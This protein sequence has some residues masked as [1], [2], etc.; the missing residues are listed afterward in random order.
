MVWRGAAVEAFSKSLN[1]VKKEGIKHLDLKCSLQ[2]SPTG[3]DPGTDFHRWNGSPHKIPLPDLQWF[4]C[5]TDYS[6][7][8]WSFLW[9]F[10]KLE[11]LLYG[12]TKHPTPT[13]SRTGIEESL[14]HNLRLKLLTTYQGSFWNSLGL[15]VL[16]SRYF[17]D[18]AMTS[19]LQMLSIDK[20]VPCI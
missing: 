9:P 11:E 14:N 5:I 13:F 7:E 3:L 4:L 19:Y 10:R 16:L 18:Y 12:P 2:I 1:Y 6:D 17:Y 20:V 8:Q 15:T